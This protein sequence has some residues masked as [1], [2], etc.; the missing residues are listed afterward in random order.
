MASRAS[1]ASY[2]SITK[3][4]ALTPRDFA[5]LAAA[6]ERL[7]RWERYSEPTATSFEWKFTRADLAAL[8]RR[9]AAHQSLQPAA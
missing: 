6:E 7:L 3:R 9:L 2:L 4:K 5:D 8:L 1:V